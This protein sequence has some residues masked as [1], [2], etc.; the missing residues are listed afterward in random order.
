MNTL[1][2]PKRASVVIIGGGI[3]GASSA[4][5]LAAAGYDVLL[6]EKGDF[7]G[8]A[9]SRSGRLLRNGAAGLAGCSIAVSDTS[10]RPIV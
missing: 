9:T 2:L 8:A 4:Q 7:G 3:S 6:V 5:H 10:P 1:P